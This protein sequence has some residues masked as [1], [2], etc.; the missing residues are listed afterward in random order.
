VTAPL[1]RLVG[2]LAT[3][4]ERGDPNADLC[5]LATARDDGAPGLRT[6]VLR[7]VS[8]RLGVFTSGT[9]PKWRQLE[10]DNRVS[11]A[12]WLP[13]L[14]VQYVIEA[15]AE[16]MP[17]AIVHASWVQRPRPAQL[18]DLYYQGTL[19]QSHPLPDRAAFEHG[20]DAVTANH[21]DDEVLEP[22]ESASGLYLNAEV[23]ERLELDDDTRRH[24][25][26]RYRLATQWEPEEL[27]P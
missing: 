7:N 21:A 11:V 18:L 26:V 22:P 15:R 27:V 6:V 1:E 5:W 23:V 10:E 16:P 3:A 19:P 2:E 20:L 13:T 8:G 25:R 4:R 17:S 12:V 9:S 14:R 24:R